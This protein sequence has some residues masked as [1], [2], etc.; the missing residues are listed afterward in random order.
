[1]TLLWKPLLAATLKPDADLD[2]LPYPLYASPKIDGIRAMVQGGVVVSRKGVPFPNAGVQRAFGGKVYEGLDMELVYGEPWAPDVF[3]KT[4]SVV[5]SGAREKA[6]IGER[7]VTGWAIDRYG[8]HDSQSFKFRYDTLGDCFEDARGSKIR[9][10]P[11]T[12]VRS[13]KDLLRFEERALARGYEGVMLRRADS[14]AYP[15]KPGKDNRSTLREFEL[16]KLKRMDHGFGA[17]VAVHPLEHN[18]NE[19]KTA[20]GKRSSKKGGI[21]VDPERVGSVT[22]RDGKYEFNVNVQTNE[23]RDKGP[24]WWQ[25]RIGSRVRYTHQSVGR[26]ESPRFPQ[27]KFEELR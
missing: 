9:R 3:N 1:M 2:T 7:E 26:K 27:C 22:L 13:S 23:L 8:A 11:Q 18:L 25:A 19:E 17:I 14:G 5:L 24:G 6:A 10:I 20:A 21:V 12:L 16:V 15:Q 4:Q